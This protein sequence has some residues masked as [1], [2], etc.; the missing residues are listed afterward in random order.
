MWDLDGSGECDM[1]ISGGVNTN[2][3]PVAVAA[4][5]ADPRE[6]KLPPGMPVVLD[7]PESPLARAFGELDRWVVRTLNEQSLRRI[8]R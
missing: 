1:V 5:D 2:L 8:P 3:A 6:R 4:S 7:H